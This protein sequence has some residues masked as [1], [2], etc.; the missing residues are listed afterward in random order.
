M[1]SAPPAAAAVVADREGAIHA[2][3]RFLTTAYVSWFCTTYASSTYPIPPG[4]CLTSPETPSLPLPPIPVGHSTDVLR[5][6]LSAQ[7]LLTIERKEV[8]WKVVPLPSDRCTIVTG[9]FGSFT[10]GLLAARRG[11]F[12]LVICPM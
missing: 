2:P 12:H 8:K 6:T 10:D 5:P 9:R 4:V 1:A 3:D 7:P 11:S